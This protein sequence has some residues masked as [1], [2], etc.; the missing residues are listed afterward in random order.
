VIDTRIKQFAVSHVWGGKRYSP[1]IRMGGDWLEGAGFP[2]GSKFW[3]EIKN[4]Q[5][6]I[7]KYDDARQLQQPK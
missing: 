6:V 1:M 4:R 2:K 3:V 7:N 5:L